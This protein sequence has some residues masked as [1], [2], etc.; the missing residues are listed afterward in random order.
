MS[1]IKTTIGELLEKLEQH[2][3]RHS[4][5][6]NEPEDTSI[7][8]VCFVIDTDSAELEN[9]VFTPSIAAQNGLREFLPVHDLQGVREYLA[10]V[11]V[12]G[13]PEAELFAIMHYFKWDTYPSE[14]ELAA[15]Q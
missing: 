8:T 9:D 11:G 4:V 10:N 2:N 1:H 15:Y 12:S 3:W 7:H 6:V 5:Y 14:R 13:T